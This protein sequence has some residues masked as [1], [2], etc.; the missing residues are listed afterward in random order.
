MAGRKRRKRGEPKVKPKERRV[1]VCRIKC[2]CCGFVSSPLALTGALY[3]CALCGAS[4]FTYE[5]P[6]IESL[7]EIAVLMGVQPRDCN[8]SQESDTDEG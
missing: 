7:D 5:G 3:T 8:L 6:G 1:A 4:L 2:R